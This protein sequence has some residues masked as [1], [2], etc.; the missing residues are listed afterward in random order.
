MLKKNVMEGLI[1][2]LM[3]GGGDFADLYL[4]KSRSLNIVL[5][6]RKIEKIT[7]GERL[8][9]GMRVLCKDRTY[10]AFTEDLSIGAMEQL[11][12]EL[13][14]RETDSLQN[15]VNPG[16]LEIGDGSSLYRIA[17]DRG[18]LAEK[19]AGLNRMNEAAWR[20]PGHLNQLTLI[21]GEMEK[22][23]WIMNSRGGYVHEAR[24]RVKTIA[25]GVFGKD[26]IVQST[27][28][29]MGALGDYGFIRQSDLGGFVEN[30]MYRGEGLLQAEEAPS[31][32]MPVV[33]SGEAGGTMVHEACGHGLEADIVE[34]GMSVY[35]GK[36][37]NKVA[38]ELITVVDDGTIRGRYGSGFFDDEG[39]K[40]KENILIEKGVLKG[41]MSDL[42]SAGKLGLE[43]SGN[44][45]REDYRSAPITRMTNTYIAKGQS[46]PEDV[47][48]S[49]DRG[50]FVRKMGGGQVNT[51]TGDFVFEVS[52][53]FL[54][55][56]GKLGRQVRGA[57][58]IG[59]GPDVLN[60]IDMV[61]G[62]FGYS[63]GTCG[64]DGQG[65]PV[66]DGQ[67]TLRI[68]TLVVGGTK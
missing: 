43:P 46:R 49:V 12:R 41:Y 53:G 3:S 51:A 67:P 19:V 10:F 47:V 7:S 64:K 33:I 17:S 52:E 1:E 21:Y 15:R 20:E 4:E 40:T 24:P 56:G 57:T 65:V 30:L 50:L 66:A 31:G 11:A 6:N 35:G 22:D 16:A 61:A 58:L 55:E 2:I 44:G 59:N 27:Y 13:A 28:E 45:R 42:L 54:I 23:V 14:S 62:D 63:L 38:S 25:Q 39:T 29:S 32:T 26:G 34:K 37:G 60:R 68:P 18:S 36:I 5:E 9:L 8:G 48:A